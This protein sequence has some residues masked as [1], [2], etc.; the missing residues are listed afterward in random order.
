MSVMNHDER[1]MRA[2]IDKFYKMVRSVQRKYPSVKIKNA[3]AV[4]AMR[5]ALNLKKESPVRFNIS[6][7]DSTLMI[8]TNKASWGCQPYFC[9][10]TKARS[11]IAPKRVSLS[12][13]PSL[14]T[15]TGQG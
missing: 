6:F 5:E 2:D 4:E 9:F 14:T 12:L 11:P 3:G 8:E 10:K 15:S 7:K 1:E 13:V